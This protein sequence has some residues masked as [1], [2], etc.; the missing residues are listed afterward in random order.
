V[1]RVSC[2]LASPEAACMHFSLL[3]MHTQISVCYECMHAFL[4]AVHECIHAFLSAVYAHRISVCYA[5]VHF[6]VLCMS[7][8]MHFSLL[9][10]HTWISLCCVGMHFSVTRDV[11]W[12]QLLQAPAIVISPQWWAIAWSCELK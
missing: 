2:A 4:C 7:A 10:M 12:D 6:S 1:K 3:C 8:H 9:C 5:Y 11:G